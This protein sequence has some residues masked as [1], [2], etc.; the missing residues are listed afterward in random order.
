MAELEPARANYGPTD[1]K[2]VVILSVIRQGWQILDM[3][4]RHGSR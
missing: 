1:F 2:S 4:N 3:D